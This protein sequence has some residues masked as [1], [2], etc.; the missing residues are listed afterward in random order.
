VQEHKFDI[1]LMDVH[2]PVMDGIA[3]TEAIRQLDAQAAALPIAALTADAYAD[4][5][6][7]CL[8]AGMDDV[9]VKPLVRAQLEQMLGR[10]LVGPGAEPTSQ[11]EATLADDPHL[12][13]G[14]LD[15]LEELGAPVAHGLLSRFAS[16]IPAREVE[17]RAALASGD[18]TRLRSTA[19]GLR[20]AAGCY[21]AKRLVALTKRLELEAAAQP[22]GDVASSV[23]AVAAELSQ[24]A[25]AVR[26][27]LAERSAT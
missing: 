8:S 11:V 27:L 19:H 7:R 26:A 9:L 5:R 1:V 16:G 13:T 2:M 15:E 12:D 22:A 14:V 23:A 10:H 20:G 3:A 25:T 24:V 21:G 6:A 17:L 4:T 18:Y